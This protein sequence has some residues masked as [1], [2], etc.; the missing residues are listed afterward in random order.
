LGSRDGAERGIRNV[1]S[2][3]VDETKRVRRGWTATSLARMLELGLLA[4]K[5]V[6]VLSEVVDLSKMKVVLLLVS[7]SLGLHLGD[8]EGGLTD[9]ASQNGGFLVQQKL[10]SVPSGLPLEPLY[11]L[12]GAA[13]IQAR[14]C[15]APPL[16]R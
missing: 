12:L 13:V 2:A 4:A 16:R 15:G 9:L 8:P 7:G 14:C 5:V 11:L 1:V 3:A 6:E 10:F